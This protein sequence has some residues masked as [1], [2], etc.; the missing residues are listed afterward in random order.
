MENKLS[1]TEQPCTIH[2]VTYRY[3]NSGDILG[4][5]G[6]PLNNIKHQDGEHTFLV[7]INPKYQ[8][9]K[10]TDLFDSREEAEKSEP[11]KFYNG[12]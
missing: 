11:A 2:S 6:I 10:T 9:I 12:R 1:K 3:Y 5:V 7:G 8:W 4:V